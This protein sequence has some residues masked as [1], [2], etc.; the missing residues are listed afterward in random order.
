M[1][2]RTK[3]C[4]ETQRVAYRKLMRSF[5]YVIH[6]IPTSPGLASCLGKL[7]L[8]FGTGVLIRLDDLL[9]L[10]SRTWEC[11]IRSLSQHWAKLIFFV[12]VVRCVC[13]P[14]QRCG[15][16]INSSIAT[17][18]RL[19]S[20]FDTTSDYIGYFYSRFAHFELVKVYLSMVT[21]DLGLRILR[22]FG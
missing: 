9:N 2:S 5:C 8:Q 22:L 19:I 21:A 18:E 10:S 13:I 4:W 7:L 16:F 17:S 1:P 6:F 14:S 20:K 15:R 12:S 3:F 11:T